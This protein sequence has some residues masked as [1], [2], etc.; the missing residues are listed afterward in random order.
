[1]ALFPSLAGGFHFTMTDDDVIS[2]TVGLE[3]DEGLSGN[4]EEC[5]FTNNLLYVHLTT[6]VLWLEGRLSLQ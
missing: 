2:V 3:G 5:D 4:S 6:I 1:M